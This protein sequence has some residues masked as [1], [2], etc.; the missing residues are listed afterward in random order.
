MFGRKRR[1]A[2]DNPDEPIVDAVAPD[3]AEAG[4]L[5]EDVEFDAEELE[6]DAAEAIA[7]D[8]RDDGPFDIDEVD[9]GGDEVQRIDLGTLILT[10]WQGLNLQLQVQEATKQVR[11]ITGIWHKSGI[12]ISLYA[13]PAS[14]GLAADQQDELIEQAQQAGGSAE[15]G[16][17]PFGPELRRILPQ[18][19]P[20]GEQLFHVS[21]V[22][23]AEGPRWLLRGTL[24]GEA[25]LPDGD[26]KARPFVEFFRNLIVRRGDSPMVPG[27]LLTMDLPKQNQG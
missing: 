20:N 2:E 8:A 23:F 19:G 4:D 24:M 11:A 12:E 16:A 13:A 18:T 21:R 9:L 26:A 17:G 15:V 7:F 10:P 3:E 25:A 5:E 6:E 22:W 14:G 27:E 1:A